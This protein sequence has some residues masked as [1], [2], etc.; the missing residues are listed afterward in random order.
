MD[1]E[2]SRENGGAR[3]KHTIDVIV[4]A[5]ATG[6]FILSIFLNVAFIVVIVVLGSLLGAT[7][8]RDTLSTG[9]KKVYTEGGSFV[10][11]VS[12][13]EI[14]LLYLTGMISEMSSGRGVFD[15]SEDPVSAITNR[16]QAVREDE[17][18]RG[19]LLVIDSPGGSVTASDHLYREI[20]RFRE[21]TGVPVVTMMKQIAAS[22][23]YY[24][25]AASDYIVAQPTTVTG[26][27][28]VIMFN[29][30]V[31]GLMDKFGV[32]YIAIKTGK[33]KDLMSPFKAAEE[34]E[35]SWMQIIVDQMLEQFVD[36][37]QKGRKNL[38]REQVLELTDGQI[39]IA[40][41]ALRLGLIDEIGY[42]ES[43]VRVLS[44]MAGVTDPVI[45][46]FERERVLRDIFGWMRL[47]LR[48][49][50][51]SE[52]LGPYISNYREVLRPYE[53]YYLWEGFMNMQ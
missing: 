13:H 32:E 18:I 22:G 29:F 46:E 53:V 37:V 49:L 51:I 21:E 39:F 20:V 6:I 30:N 47:R 52:V 5:V 35:I 12:R 44:Q 8:Y 15:Y 27:I 1:A 33:Y 38:S 42:M 10:S 4:R 3:K 40:K 43:A 28:G 45:V 36:A 50:S 31:K 25:A 14:A 48:P 23:G 7:K 34:E 41:D 2:R 11:K 24:V 26:S 19:V 16:L 17:K 9:Y